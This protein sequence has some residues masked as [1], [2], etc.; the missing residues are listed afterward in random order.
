MQNISWKCSIL[1]VAQIQGWGGTSRR[2]PN[3]LKYF[4]LQTFET[5][6]GRLKVLPLLAYL[7]L[8]DDWLSK[9]CGY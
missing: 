4:L 8:Y 2:I 7:I 1:I 5:F 9:Y 6:I 3:K